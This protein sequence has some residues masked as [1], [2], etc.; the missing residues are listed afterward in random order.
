MQDLLEV[1]ELK[2]IECLNEQSSHNAANAIKQ[3]YR[4]DDGLYLE[5]DADEQLLINIP[6]NQAVKLSSITIKGPEDGSAP[7][8]V[9]LYVNRPSLGFSDTDAVCGRKGGTARTSCSQSVGSDAGR[10]GAPQRIAF[11]SAT[12]AA[13]C[14]PLRHLCSATATC[15]RAAAAQR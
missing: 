12:A 2:S 5:S 4:E 11:C 9:K 7:K 13:P 14:G 6:F 1:I 15:R 8:I 10:S 3:G